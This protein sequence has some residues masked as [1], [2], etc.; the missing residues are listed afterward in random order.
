MSKEINNTGQ[1]YALAAGG[2]T[3]MA[4][5]SATITLKASHPEIA[6][7]EVLITPGEEPPL[8]VHKNEDEWLYVLEG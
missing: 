5:F 3:A 1:P 7:T 2:G 6:V 8:H 4:W